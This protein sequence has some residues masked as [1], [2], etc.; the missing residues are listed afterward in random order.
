[1]NFLERLLNLLSSLFKSFRGRPKRS[2]QK[3]H[4]KY[5][6]PKSSEPPKKI[7]TPPPPEE[8]ISA[9]EKIFEPEEDFF[10]PPAEKNFSIETF[11]DAPREKIFVLDIHDA[12]EL[13][14]YF[15]RLQN[16]DSIKN[17]SSTH[18]LRWADTRLADA[19][20]V[21]KKIRA[22][23]DFDDGEFNFKLACK[24]RDIANYMLEIFSNAKDSPSLDDW[25]RT[26]LRNSVEE[27]LS[28]VGLVQK[29]F[30]PGD[31]YDDWANLSMKN[32]V[33]TVSTAERAL[34]SKIVSVEV[35]PHVI[36]YRDEQGETEQLIF[37]GLCKI[38]K[39]K[40]G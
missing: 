30:S 25:S 19:E 28:S 35:Q 4:Q 20:K 9:P 33:L 27:Y 13:E 2:P 31:S 10:A 16:F 23:N 39:F 32:S 38:Y 22:M 8:K 11:A 24:V 18:H 14:N 40:E 29:K 15:A 37:G 6:P 3:V 21:L 26:Q 5:S 36:N 1:M 12:E 34:H 7:F 17:F